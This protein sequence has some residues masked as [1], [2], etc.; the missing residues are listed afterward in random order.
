VKTFK[1]WINV[2]DILIGLFLYTRCNG[3]ATQFWNWVIIFSVLQI[4]YLSVKNWSVKMYHM[5]VK[6]VL[7]MGRLYIVQ[8][9]SY[10]PCSIES[11]FLLHIN[12]HWF[13]QKLLTNCFII[14]SLTYGLS[15]KQHLHSFDLLDFWGSLSHMVV[16]SCNMLS[17]ESWCF[18]NI[19]PEISVR[20]SY[21]IANFV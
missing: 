10:A 14:P 6:L 4:W 21:I 20:I 2:T 7:R 19:S 1:N 13:C 15:N 16:M 9:T 11:N 12:Y 3:Y 5:E 17:R 18:V 8:L